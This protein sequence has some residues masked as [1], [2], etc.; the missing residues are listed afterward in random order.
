MSRVKRGIGHVKRR[1]NILKAAKG[2]QW[3][4]K[5][6]IKAAKTAITKAGMKAF[7]GRRE[8]KR[9]MRQGWNIVMSAGLKEHGM[10]YSKFIGALKQQKIELNRK[11]LA[12]IA[13]HHP[14]IWK[15]L[16]EKVRS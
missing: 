9:V 16:L 15:T 4:R 7:I 13:L 3:G 1:R 8:K 11:M 6:T 12:D 14:E 2:F 5:N 10:S